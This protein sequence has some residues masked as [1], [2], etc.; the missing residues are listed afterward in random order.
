MLGPLLPLAAFR[1]MKAVT[2]SL[3]PIL[4][5]FGHGAFS[6]I[7]IHLSGVLQLHRCFWKEQNRKI[8]SIPQF[9]WTV[10]PGPSCWHC[11]PS[12]KSQL[13]GLRC[14]VLVRSLWRMDL[15]YTPPSPSLPP[16]LQQMSPGCPL[17]ASA[18]V[19]VV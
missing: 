4:G 15:D 1:K 8:G 19:S 17:G 16:F 12:Q 5:P 18:G 3:G 11:A 10:R 13:P 2:A 6:L 9:R 14:G 7:A